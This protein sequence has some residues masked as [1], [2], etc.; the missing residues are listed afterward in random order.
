MKKRDNLILLFFILIKF[1]IQYF[2]VHPVYEL[3]R[4]EFLHL[5]Q[6]KHLS[7]GYLSVPPFSSWIAYTINLL[8]NE[9]FWIRFFPALFGA[10]TIYVVWKT[11][12]LLNGNL[13]AKILGAMVILF[14]VLLRMN[15]LFHPNSFDILAWTFIYY[16]F[17][18]Y[19]VTEKSKWIYITAIAF[20]IGILNKYNIVFIVPGLIITTLF[21]KQRR[22]YA[23]KHLYLAIVVA[24][25]IVSPNIVWQYDNGFPV[26]HHMKILAETQLE[27]VNRIDFLKEQILYFFG[28]LFVL[29]AGLI[30]FWK[31]ENFRAYRFL[32]FSFFITLFLFVYLKAKGY[33][34]IGL[35]P[36]YIAFGAVWL[37]DLLAKPSR[38]WLR[39]VT[40]SIPV[41][42]SVPLF[43][44]AFPNKTPQY[45][46]K[47]P[48]IYK[49]LGLLRWED[50][51]DHELP[52][53]FADMQGWKELAAKVD[54]IYHLQKGFTLIHCDNYGQAGAINYYSSIKELEAYS[55]NADYIDWIPLDK[56]VVNMIFVRD[57]YD[58]DPERTDELSLFESI[59]L[60][61]EITNPFAREKGTKI[62]LLKKAKVDVNAI[63]RQDIIDRKK[64]D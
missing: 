12:E 2:L 28:G 29:V 37:G 62:Y 31:N 14:S 53:D 10:L 33:Y 39:I 35:Y 1:I 51:K 48:D 3:H 23:D 20:G 26:I 44:F 49:S 46:S 36:V 54:S 9:E 61:G 4:D 6:G 34:A 52:Q 27:N 19:L 30:S 7:W 42:L 56:P 24:L 63:I 25:V 43:N 45:I 16:S 57:V 41:A 38:R 8:G 58:K 13:Y 47:H 22:I 17:L 15:I 5:D 40:V 64:I 60:I 18:R 50:G 59:E 32:F 21:S 11:V 55:Y